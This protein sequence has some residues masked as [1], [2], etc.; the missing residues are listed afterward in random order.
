LHHCCGF[1]L[2]IP[3]SPIFDRRGTKPTGFNG[4]DHLPQ[5][6]AAGIKHHSSLLSSEIDICDDDAGQ[7]VQYLTDVTGTS[8][9]THA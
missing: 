4:S 5:G 8:S 2:N 6:N 3:V 9:T 1:R 7:S